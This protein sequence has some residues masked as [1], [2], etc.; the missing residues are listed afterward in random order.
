[1]ARILVAGATGRLGRHI[2]S[3][4]KKRGHWVRALTRNPIRPYPEVDELVGGDLNRLHTLH[5]PCGRVDAIIS[6]AGA[7]VNPFMARKASDYRR[8]DYEGNRNL[9]RVAGASGIRR[10]VYVSVFSVPALQNLDYVRAH[11]LFAKELKA[12]GLSYAIVQ[13]TG[14]FSA[15]DTVL[16]MSRSGVVPL[17]GDG[18]ARTNPIHERDLARIVVDALDGP[19]REIPAGGPEILTRRTIFE[20]AFQALDKKPRFIRIPGPVV[21]AQSRLIGLFDPRMAQLTAFMKKV[22]QVD[23]IA[24]RYGVERLGDYFA[25]KAS[26][27]TG[28]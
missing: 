1:M 15:F 23:V 25:E 27:L 19:E 14:F 8:V 5:G 13:P 11:A 9:L 6:A 22:S 3:E 10:F 2:V 7:S 17:I 28:G 12:S 20:L 18:S 21:T 16:E 24:P 4:L 26:V